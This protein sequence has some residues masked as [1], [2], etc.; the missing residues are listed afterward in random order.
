MAFPIVQRADTTYHVTQRGHR[1]ARLFLEEADRRDFLG[2]LTRIARRYGWRVFAYCLM[3]NHV[4]LVLRTPRPDLSEGM[5]RLTAAFARRFNQRHRFRGTP[6]QGRYRAFVVESDEHFMNS[7]RYCALNPVMAH[8]VRTAEQW[9]WSHHRAMLGM[10][11]A[12][13]WLDVHG[14]LEKFEGDSKRYRSFVDT[15]HLGDGSPY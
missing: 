5:A 3:H 7:V 1:G 9:E 2:L 12:P 4:H 15:W 6:F 8:L 11:P 13:F 10:A 14:V